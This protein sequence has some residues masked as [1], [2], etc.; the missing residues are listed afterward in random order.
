MVNTL[1][2]WDKQHLRSTGSGDTI[3]ISSKRRTSSQVDQ[4]SQADKLSLTADQLE[5]SG[6]VIHLHPTSYE[7]V[8]KARKAGRGVRL[9][10]TRHEIKKGYK[11]AQGGSIWSK[12]KS[13]LSSAFKFVANSGLL[14]R[15]LDAAVPALATAFGGP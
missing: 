13:G 9:D 10:I 8:I 11:R 12:I 14:S 15:G 6:S 2:Q 4:S 7:K 5:G 3:Q 1:I